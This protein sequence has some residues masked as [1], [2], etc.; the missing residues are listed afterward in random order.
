VRL[1]GWAPRPTAA[2]QGL[3][4]ALESALAQAGRE[5]PSVTE[6]TAAHGPSVPSLL[7]LLERAGR[8]VQVEADRY[9]DA[10][11]VDELLGALRRGMAPGRSYGPAELRELLGVSRKYL[12]PF[13]EFADR[14][15]VT[16]RR[17][18]GRVLR[19]V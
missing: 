12:I 15:N 11:A 3:L 14:R 16:D 10:A 13:L 5:P 9:Y 19:A 4:A 18:D 17:A 2:Q 7:R 1:A 8:V 6:L